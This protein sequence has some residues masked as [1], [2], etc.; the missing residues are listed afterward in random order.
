MII[1][2]FAK[3]TV[4]YLYDPS[5]RYTTYGRRSILYA[6]DVHLRIL[7]C[8]H[9]EDNVPTVI[10]LLEAS[11]PTRLNP[12]SVYVLHL[13]ELTGRAAATLVPHHHNLKKTTAKATT[14]E[15]IANACDFYE[16]QH[17]GTVVVQHFAAT[18]PYSSIH[19]DI[20]S[21]ALDKRTNI[22]ILPFHNHWTF[23][24]NDAGSTLRSAVRKVNFNV[25][26]K[27]PCSIGILIDRGHMKG[28]V[29]L[30][31]FFFKV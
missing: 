3:P 27:S 19:N 30:L 17:Q 1:T 29:E 11:N 8:I 13:M 22:V 2:G 10:K 6:N 9:N 25:I 14:S 12:I 7:V 18:A 16:Q 31:F 15:H 5:R 20:C 28:T 26:S 24:Q 21:L 23:D 4:K